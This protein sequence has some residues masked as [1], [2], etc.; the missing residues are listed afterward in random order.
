MKEI[1]AGLRERARRERAQKYTPSNFEIILNSPEILA[2]GTVASYVSYGFE[3]STQEINRSL[4]NEGKLL[5]L[6]RINESRLEWIKWDGEQDSLKENNKILEPTGLAITDLSI[7]DVVIVPA[8]RVDQVGYRLGQ[9]GGFYDRTLVKLEVWKVGLIYESE[10]TN[11]AL[12][13][14][15]HDICLDAAATPTVIYRFKK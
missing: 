8:L 10:I 3:P 14:E 2:A 4:L 7:I 9:G 5:L 15:T 11:Q 6:P 13:H 1:K 12:P